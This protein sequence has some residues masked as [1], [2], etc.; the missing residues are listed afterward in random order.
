MIGGIA[1]A[2]PVAFESWRYE[3][4]WE[5]DEIDAGHPLLVVRR[6]YDRWLD[7]TVELD[8][9]SVSTGH[10]LYLYRLESGGTMHEAAWYPDG[11][12]QEQSLRSKRGGDDI[13]GPPWQRGIEDGQ[14]D[15]PWLGVGFEEWRKSV[16]FVEPIS[17]R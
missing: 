10:R 12:V 2:T 5:L 16:R 17:P 1:L 4:S 6:E 11:T 7:D 9:W 13:P 14:R 8:K 3:E 15:A